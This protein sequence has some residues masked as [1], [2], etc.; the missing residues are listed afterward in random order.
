MCHRAIEPSANTLNFYLTYTKTR[1]P[2]LSKF[3]IK[4]I[5]N[6]KLGFSETQ[7]LVDAM[8]TNSDLPSLLTF[9]IVDDKETDTTI[10]SAEI[11]EGEYV[12]F[13]PLSQPEADKVAMYSLT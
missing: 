9:K 1:I 7:G 2:G 4:D 10:G 5:K 11:E 12:S 3:Q 6:K 13:S 8:R